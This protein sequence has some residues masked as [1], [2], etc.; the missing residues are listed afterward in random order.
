MKIIKIYLLSSTLVI[1]TKNVY[2][3]C[4]FNM[5]VYSIPFNSILFI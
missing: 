2:C 3:N 1:K 5:E 4:H